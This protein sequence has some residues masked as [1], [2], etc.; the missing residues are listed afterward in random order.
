LTEKLRE[1][2]AERPN[3]TDIASMAKSYREREV[4]VS[5]IANLATGS[6]DGLRLRVNRE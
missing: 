5:E 1:L 4:R 3:L 6:G 2:A